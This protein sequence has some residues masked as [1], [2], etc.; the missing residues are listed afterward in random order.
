MVR[1]R[2]ATGNAADGGAG[3]TVRAVFALGLGRRC[4]RGLWSS[5]RLPAL[6][7]LLLTA[8]LD[9]VCAGRGPPSHSVPA[10]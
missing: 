1:G 3:G 6:H 8:S 2:Q 7:L 9:F 4:S 10:A 5:R